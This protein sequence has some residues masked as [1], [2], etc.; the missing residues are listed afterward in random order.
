[1]PVEP[2]QDKFDVQVEG[3]TYTFKI[4]TIKYDIEVGYRAADVRAKAY[5]EG[6]GQMAGLDW[7]A[8][9]FS[10]YCAIL[11]LYLIKS[12]TLWPYGFAEDDLTKVDLNAPPKVEFDK[13]PLSASDDVFAVGQAFE[14]E[15]GRFR[16]RR[17]PDPAPAGA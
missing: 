4:P 10:R 12:T 14:T 7:Q 16:R 8:V 15:V 13:F 17:H 3:A 11:E 6:A 9:S 1:M 2:L 5:P